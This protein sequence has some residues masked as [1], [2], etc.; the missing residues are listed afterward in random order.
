MAFG[1]GIYMSD[2]PALCLK[3][4]NVLV[5]CRVLLGRVVR[6]TGSVSRGPGT[7][8]QGGVSGRGRRGHHE[9]HQD[10]RPGPAILRHQPQ[11]GQPDPNKWRLLEVTGSAISVPSPSPSPWSLAWEQRAGRSSLSPSTQ[12]DGWR[13]GLGLCGLLLQELWHQSDGSL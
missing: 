7:G 3:H 12:H 2:Y 13:S 1:R 9:S 11:Q 6:V 4:G 5:V 10:S 8:H